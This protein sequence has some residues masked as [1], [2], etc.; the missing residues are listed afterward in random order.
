MPAW[1]S[2]ARAGDAAGYLFR[3]GGGGGG[4]PGGGGVVPVGATGAEAVA[5]AD[6][7]AACGR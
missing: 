7:L 6:N 2:L 5:E 4:E 1:S 3:S